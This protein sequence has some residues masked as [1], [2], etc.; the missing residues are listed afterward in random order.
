MISSVLPS[1]KPIRKER[2]GLLG[3][4]LIF[5]HGVVIEGELSCGLPDDPWAKSCR[6]CKCRRHRSLEFLPP[7]IGDRGGG[8]T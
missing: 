6:E 1:V 4:K 8:G 7:G 3:L 2:N 5:Y